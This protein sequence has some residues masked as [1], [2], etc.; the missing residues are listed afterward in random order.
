V[1]FGARG[2]KTDGFDSK[3][4]QRLKRPGKF[5]DGHGLYLQVHGNNRSWIFRYKRFGRTRWMGLGSVATYTLDEARELARKARQ[6]IKQGVDPL[7]AR[8]ACIAAE[9]L[10]ANKTK[11][12]QQCAE[13]Y[14]AAHAGNWSAKAQDDFVAALNTYVYPHC[15]SVPVAAVDTQ[16]VMQCLLPIW[17][18]K[19][20]TAKRARGRMEDILHWATVQGF[21]TGENPA[22]WEKHL[23]FLLPKPNA[24][25]N[26][27]AALPYADMPAFMAALRVLEGIPARAL[28]LTVL[29]A[30]RT[31]ETLGA[32]W[33]E[34]NL[35]EKVWTVPAA[36]MKAGDR[37]HRIPLSDRCVEILQ[38]L[39]RM[40]EY[41]FPVIQ[42]GAL[43]PHL[44]SKGMVRVLQRM[45]YSNSQ[46][47]VH[48]FRSTFR[49]W[50]AECTNTP[51]HVVEMALAHKIANKVEAAYRRSDLFTKRRVLMAAWA[52]Y[53]HRAPAAVARLAA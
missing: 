17:L 12:F 3:K 51:N 15:G 24:N 33:G 30:T 5:A 1:G 9:K 41:V 16:M 23:E 34:I 32:K 42:N 50:S 46:A 20:P 40:N 10:A 28:E 11:T 13:G 19:T 21:R 6:Q 36:R 49:D 39:P 2:N 22:R 35:E 8:Q 14:L 44:S 26:H 27:H 53:C 31:N 25:N 29:C 43:T 48:G 45:G 4:V 52:G 37:A 47:T 18:T 38:H 7:L